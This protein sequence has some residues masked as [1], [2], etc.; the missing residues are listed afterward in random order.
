MNNEKILERI[1]K[2]EKEL[3][4]VKK[5]LKSK[6]IDYTEYHLLTHG[7][8]DTDFG[9]N[10]IIKSTVDSKTFSENIGHDENFNYYTGI[11]QNDCI[12][13]LRKKRR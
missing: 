13:I 8:W 9:F 7:Y 10:T 3:E 6:T 11:D 4:E 2:A 1:E 5:E 12:R